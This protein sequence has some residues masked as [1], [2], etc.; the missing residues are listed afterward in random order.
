MTTVKERI[1]HQSIS[2]IEKRIKEID[3]IVFSNSLSEICQLRI[4]AQK[5]LEENRGD[6]TKI[7][8]LITPLAEREKKLFKI[9]RN[10]VDNSIA[11]LKEKGKIEIELS[12]LKNELYFIKQRA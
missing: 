11:L 9:A 5:I 7:A 10:Q 2:E 3:K 4:D 1:I 8:E 12:E 6:Y